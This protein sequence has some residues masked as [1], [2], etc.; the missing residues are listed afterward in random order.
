MPWRCAPFDGEQIYALLVCILFEEVRPVT[1]RR[2]DVPLGVSELIQRLLSRI[3][4]SHP[5]RCGFISELG[6]LRLSV[7][8]PVPDL[9]KLQEPTSSFPGKSGRCS[10]W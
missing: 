4:A 8:E 6:K 2:P 10:V 7:R 1:T 3:R 9:T 5:D